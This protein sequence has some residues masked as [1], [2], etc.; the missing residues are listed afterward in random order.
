M[1]GHRE[2][3]RDIVSRQSDDPYIASWCAKG[4]ALVAKIAEVVHQERDPWSIDDL[5]IRTWMA[6][7]GVLMRE[8][9][10]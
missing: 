5:E 8:R 2:S 3:V 9:G 4:D 1:L 7:G 6:D 10:S